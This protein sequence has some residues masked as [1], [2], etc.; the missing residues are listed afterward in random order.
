[1][2]RPQTQDV[3][4]VSEIIKAVKGLGMKCGRS[5]FEDGMAEDFKKQVWTIT[6]TISIPTLSATTTLSTR[7][8]TKT[9]WI[10]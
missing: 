6:T 8:N 5:V 2:A 7:A 10:P 3:E 4:T 1:M 9:A